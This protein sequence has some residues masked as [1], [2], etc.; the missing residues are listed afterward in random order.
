MVVPPLRCEAAASRRCPRRGYAGC[1]QRF[2]QY[3]AD[4][5][6]HSLTSRVVGPCRERRVRSHVAVDHWRF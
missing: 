1:L 3:V 5:F 6:T 4:S 2:D